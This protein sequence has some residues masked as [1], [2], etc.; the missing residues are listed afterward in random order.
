MGRGPDAV[1]AERVLRVI[2][3]SDA[4]SSALAASGRPGTVY[5]AKALQ[6]FDEFA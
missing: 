5:A 1:H 3:G 4:A 6:D 2:S